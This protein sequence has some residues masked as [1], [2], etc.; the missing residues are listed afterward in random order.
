MRRLAAV[1]VVAVAFSLLLA[2][3]YSAPI[4][5]DAFDRGQK[6][7]VV[8]VHTDGKIMPEPLETHTP[9]ARQGTVWGGEELDARRVFDAMHPVVMEALGRS[10]HFRLLPEAKVLASPAYAA[11]RVEP[12]WG[13]IVPKG[14][15]WAAS[16]SAYPPVLR[17]LGADLGI[18]LLFNLFYGRG[19]GEAKMIVY[20][21]I[22]DA[23]GQTVWKGG[24]KTQSDRPVNVVAAS[25]RERIEVFRELARKAMGEVEEEMTAQLAAARGTRAPAR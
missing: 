10:A 16:D 18:G 23:N 20:V 3:G 11:L 17:E 2:C 25:E 21:G 9:G 15:Q 8:L 14:Y 4:R 19:G 5:P 12:K 13:Y 1:V 6:A 24:T 7:A 22:F